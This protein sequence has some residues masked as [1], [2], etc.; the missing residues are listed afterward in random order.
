MSVAEAVKLMLDFGTFILSLIS[1]IVVLI[2]LNHDQK[3]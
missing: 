2:K 3:K 1:L